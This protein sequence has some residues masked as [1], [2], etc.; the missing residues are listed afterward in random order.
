MFAFADNK[1]LLGLPNVWTP[2]EQSRVQSRWH[3]D[4]LRLIAETISSSPP[5]G[6]AT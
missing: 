2:V 3:F 4:E 6:R 5:A 1:F